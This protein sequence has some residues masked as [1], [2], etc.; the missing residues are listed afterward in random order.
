MSLYG[1]AAMAGV[2]RS[3]CCQQRY[4]STATCATERRQLR[5]RDSKSALFTRHAHRVLC[6]LV[7]TRLSCKSLECVC[8][9]RAVVR[10]ARCP[11]CQAFQPAYEA[12]ASY[13]HSEP[14]VQPEVWVARVDCADEV[15][16]PALQVCA[17]H[18][19]YRLY[20]MSHKWLQLLL[21]W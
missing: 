6:S 8:M 19:W 16:A 5:Q 17:L 14:R 9:L 10:R 2:W 20:Y 15:C 3:D 4:R 1:A 11:S 13:F 12:V 18:V 21:R 7:G